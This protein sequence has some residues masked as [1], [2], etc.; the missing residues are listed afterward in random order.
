MSKKDNVAKLLVEMAGSSKRE[1]I[2]E[3]VAR[4]EMSHAA[5]STYVYSM[6]RDIAPSAPTVNVV[7]VNETDEEIHDRLTKRFN[8]MKLMATSAAK[9]QIPALIISG[10]A[11]VGKTHDVDAAVKKL[12]PNALVI[13]GHVTSTGL[14]R[15]LWRNRNKGD[16]VMFDDADSV[17]SSEKT[18][19]LLKAAC[20]ST[21]V[22]VITSM[23]KNAIT[24]EGEDDEG[25]AV[26]EDIPES[27]VFEGSIV[28]IT[29]L[30]F[31]NLISADNRMSPHFAALRSRSHYIDLDMHTV[32]E[33]LVRIKQVVENSDML[34]ARGLNKKQQAEIVDFFVTN[35]PLMWELSLRSLKKLVDLY[36]A[37]PSQYQNIAQV[38]MFKKQV[39][40]V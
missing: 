30:D 34:S 5:A 36:L 21:D 15:A 8:V 32:R 10:P 4:F 29:N 7:E 16:V 11:G 13:K 26:Q 3:A 35:A 19:N 6:A 22:R 18:L 38:T 17:F 28:F 14:L 23:G 31:A 2:A 40:R 39:K 24:S 1:I 27:F 37:D 9:G 33:Y 12:S 20:D 25:E